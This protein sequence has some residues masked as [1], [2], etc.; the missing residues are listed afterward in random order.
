[1]NYG[2]SWTTK[3]TS[4]GSGWLLIQTLVRL[5]VFTLAHG[6]KPQHAS[7]GNLCLRFIASVPSPIPTFGQRMGQC[8]ARK[9]HRAVGKETGKTTYIERFNNTLRQRVSR[10]VRKTLSFSKSLEN[11]IGAIWYFI[12]HY[13]AS[14]LM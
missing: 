12:H 7:Y 9:R 2:H 14:L 10:L 4:S 5:S 11:H 3:G 13:N 6:M 8:Y 1:M